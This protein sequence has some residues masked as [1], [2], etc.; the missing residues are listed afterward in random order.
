MSW[1]FE[2]SAGCQDANASRCQLIRIFIVVLKYESEC[3]S[4]VLRSC[5]QDYYKNVKVK[6]SEISV[7]ALLAMRAVSSI[8]CKRKNFRINRPK[9]FAQKCDREETAVLERNEVVIK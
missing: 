4:P 8:R 6:L 2:K 1:P 3:S 9:S 5:K 7:C